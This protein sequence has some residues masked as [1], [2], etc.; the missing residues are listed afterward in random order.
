M[1]PSFLKHK[2]NGHLCDIKCQTVLAPRAKLLGM[3][4]VDAMM[5]SA[6]WCTLIAAQSQFVL[7]CLSI[8][9][10]FHFLKEKRD[11]YI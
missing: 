7:A 2:V 11:M 6:L 9:Y 3:R 1:N 10:L 8:A 4:N 5:T